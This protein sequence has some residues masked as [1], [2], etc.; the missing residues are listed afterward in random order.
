MDKEIML[1]KLSNIGLAAT[2]EVIRLADEAGADRDEL[3][4]NFAS[5]LFNMAVNCTFSEF[6]LE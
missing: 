6:E 3:I 5:N 1:D 4:F 2:K